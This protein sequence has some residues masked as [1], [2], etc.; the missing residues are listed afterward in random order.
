MVRGATHDDNHI[1][2]EASYADVDGDLL[3]HSWTPDDLPLRFIVQSK[4]KDDT[5]ANKWTGRVCH[6][7]ATSLPCLLSRRE[8][9]QAHSK[10]RLIKSINFKA[11]SSFQQLYK[12]LCLPR[13]PTLFI[14]L[15]L[16]TLP[17]LLILSLLSIGGFM[18]TLSID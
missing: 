18:T 16:S 13:W 10:N 9:K 8:E 3:L 5:D 14:R 15:P 2:C 4:K 1:S 7:P 11:L 17:V 12:S 6:S